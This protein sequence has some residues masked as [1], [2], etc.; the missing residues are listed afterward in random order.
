MPLCAMCSIKASDELLTNMK[1][2][3]LSLVC[4]QERE[5][6]IYFIEDSSKFSGHPTTP[7]QHFDSVSVWNCTYFMIGGVIRTSN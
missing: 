4:V 3:E 5:S 6:G 7:R 2:T 1:I